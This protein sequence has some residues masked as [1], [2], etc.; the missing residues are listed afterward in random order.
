ML[1]F[2]QRELDGISSLDSPS[3]D[4]RMPPN[5]FHERMDQDTGNTNFNAAVG[6]NINR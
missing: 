4:E 2:I 6:R 3:S 5:H 1:D